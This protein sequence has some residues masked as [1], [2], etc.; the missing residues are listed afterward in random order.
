MPADAP[1][2]TSERTRSAHARTLEAIRNRPEIAKM[3]RRTAARI[4]DGLT[5]ETKL[6]ERASIAAV[7]DTAGGD[8]RGPSQGACL[9][10]SL[11]SSLAI[12]IAGR[13][14]GLGI[15]RDGLEAKVLSAYDL[16]GTCGA[17]TGAPTGHSGLSNRVHV[18]SDAEEARVGVGGRKAAR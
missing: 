15:A 5:C 13:Y 16:R 4:T 12:G 18:E 2:D 9:E 10:A 3:G 11:A 17:E 1:S 14:A 8:D 7:P 6:C